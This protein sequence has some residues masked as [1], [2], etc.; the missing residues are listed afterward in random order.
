MTLEIMKITSQKALKSVKKLCLV[1][2]CHV[3]SKEIL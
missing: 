3:L 1:L 2:V